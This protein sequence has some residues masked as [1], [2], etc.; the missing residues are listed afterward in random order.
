MTLDRGVELR[1]GQFST[2]I[3]PLIFLCCKQGGD[4]FFGRPRRMVF[5]LIRPRANQ[6]PFHAINRVLDASM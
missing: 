5:C 4:L 1:L 3:R 2:D 6:S